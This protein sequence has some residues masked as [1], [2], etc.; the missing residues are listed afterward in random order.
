MC[1]DSFGIESKQGHESHDSSPCHDSH[2]ACMPGST[3][4]PISR[5]CAALPLR[6]VEAGAA[7]PLGFRMRDMLCITLS[8][9]VCACVSQCECRPASGSLDVCA[10]L[11]AAVARPVPPCPFLSPRLSLMNL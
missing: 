1:A 8:Q 4:P 5:D 6:I 10:V 3:A 2:N 9:G 11:L 7:L